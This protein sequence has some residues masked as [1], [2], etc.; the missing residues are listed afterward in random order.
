MNAQ[1][2]YEVRV[3][4]VNF[5]SSTISVYDPDNSEPGPASTR[6][7]SARGPFA[8]AFDPFVLNDVATNA[9][10]KPTSGHDPRL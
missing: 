2:N 8:M 5:D 7:T 4:V 1:G 9:A 10:V 3:F 6:S